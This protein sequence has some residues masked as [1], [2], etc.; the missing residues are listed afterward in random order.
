MN[1]R[2]ATCAKELF[3]MFFKLKDKVLW[4]T[5]SKASLV[6]IHLVSCTFIGLLMGY[7]LDKWMGTRPWLLVAFLIFGI[8][9]GFKNMYEEIKKIQGAEKGDALPDE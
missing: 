5:L 2:A 4:Q 6:G 1:E 9:A 7:Y 3:N 8:A